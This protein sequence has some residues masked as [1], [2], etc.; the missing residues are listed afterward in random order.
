MSAAE[1]APAHAVG[2]GGIGAHLIALLIAVLV[3]FWT[4]LPIYNMILVSLE[5][6]DAIF[7]GALWPENFSLENFRIVF[8]QDYWYLQHFWLQMLNSLIVGLAAAF[9]TVLIGSMASFS[10]QR[11]RLRYGTLLSNTALLSYAIPL[12]FLAI[13]F[14]NILHNY[15]LLDN[16]WALIIVAVTFA[17]PYAIFIFS[18]YSAS[19]PIELDEAA[20]IDGATVPQIYF[21][22]YIPLMR[23]ALVAVGTYALL[24]AWNEYLYAFLLLSSETK[25][26]VPVA[27]GY[28]LSSDDSPWNILMAAALIYSIPPLIIYY[29]MRKHMTT[30]LTVGSVKG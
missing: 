17:T 19:I 26:T 2:K 7:S 11:L 21:K 14:Y 23:P 13:P 18:Q 9:F 28:F 5:P 4:L 30:G 24:L 22:L 15:G 16:L 25:V 10:I 6:G 27:L 8:T 20:R 3:L 1:S 12:S 29:A